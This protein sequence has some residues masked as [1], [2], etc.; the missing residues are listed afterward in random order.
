MASSI[1][2]QVP[3]T[4]WVSMPAVLVIGPT[5]MQNSLGQDRRQPTAAAKEYIMCSVMYRNENL[6]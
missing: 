2:S 4:N 5:A 6:S 3:L 1:N